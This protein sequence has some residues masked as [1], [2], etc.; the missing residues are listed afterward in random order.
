MH[1]LSCYI[2]LFNSTPY[3]AMRSHYTLC[4]APNAPTFLLYPNIQLKP[5]SAMRSHC[6]VCGAPNAPTFL[7]YPNIQLNT[8]FWNALTLY[9]LRCSQRSKRIPKI[10][11][12][13]RSAVFLMHLLSC[14][15]Q[16]FNSTPC[17]AMR[18]HYTVCGA[19]NACS[20][21]RSHYTVCC[22]HNGQSA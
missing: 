21:M 14:Y 19:H 18:S 22:A 3:S 7:L 6:T 1:L 9:A 12:T 15:I 11:R 17:S 4:G 13:V 16:L 8:L 2:Q 10:A 5:C 20:T